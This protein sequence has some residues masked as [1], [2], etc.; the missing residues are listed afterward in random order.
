MNLLTDI[1]FLKLKSIIPIEKYK[2]N[3]FISCTKS[4]LLRILN[5]LNF[6][7]KMPRY[8]KASATVDLRSES[9]TKGLTV[10]TRSQ[11]IESGNSEVVQKSNEVIPIEENQVVVGGNQQVCM[12]SNIEQAISMVPNTRG[13]S[14]NSSIFESN[15]NNAKV[16]SNTTIKKNTDIPT[17]NT[18]PE[19]SALSSDLSSLP[20][21][22]SETSPSASSSNSDISGTSQNSNLTDRYL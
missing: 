14:T 22:V 11:N 20:K 5:N 8:D 18:K 7:R 3:D 9:K 6:F 16:A 4:F 21:N 15:S 19:I 12:D 17:N 1:Y 13:T 10:S 2:N